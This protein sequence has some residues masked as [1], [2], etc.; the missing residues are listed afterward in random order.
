MTH[1]Y[2]LVCAADCKVLPIAEVGNAERV[3]AQVPVLGSLLASSCEELECAIQASHCQRVGLLC[4]CV[5]VCVCVV[6]A[7]VCLSGHHE[8]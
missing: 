7:C 8:K 5:R 4:V 2:S 3:K 6:C 1:I